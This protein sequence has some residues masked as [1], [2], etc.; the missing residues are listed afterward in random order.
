MVGLGLIG[1][2]GLCGSC[3]VVDADDEEDEEA[4]GG[5]YWTPPLALRPKVRSLCRAPLSP[6]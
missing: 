3:G 4:G 6:A 5:E 1:V 2:T